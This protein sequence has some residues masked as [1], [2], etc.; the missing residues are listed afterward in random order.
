[1][2]QVTAKPGLALGSRFIR[3]GQPWKVFAVTR[4]FER[5]P[6]Q[7]H[8]HLVADNRDRD[9][10]TIAVNVLLDRRFFTPVE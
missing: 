8:A 9:E 3:A 7:P 6:L 10:A 1:M 4:I 2:V 5:P